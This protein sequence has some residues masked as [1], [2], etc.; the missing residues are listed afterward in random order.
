MRLS[1][2]LLPKGGRVIVFLPPPLWGRVGVGGFFPHQLSPTRGEG[3]NSYIAC[4]IVTCR[5]WFVLKSQIRI[6]T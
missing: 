5:V 4:T 6:V 2:S 1:F 3:E